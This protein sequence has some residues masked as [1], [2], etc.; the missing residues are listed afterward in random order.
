MSDALRKSETEL[1]EALC[2]FCNNVED[3]IPAVPLW[4]ESVRRNF[5]QLCEAYSRWTEQTHIRDGQK[6]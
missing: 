6:L 5:E 4:T 1:D 3:P 2:N